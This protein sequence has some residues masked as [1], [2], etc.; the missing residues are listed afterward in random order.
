M[1][2]D[3]VK[4]SIAAGNGGNGIVSF[5][6]EIYVDKGGPDGGDGGKG[7]DVILKASNNQNTLAEFRYKKLLQ[8]ENGQ[9]GSASRKRG[10][11]A[12]NLIVEVP[13]GTSVIT[14]KGTMIVDLTQDGQE[15]IVAQGGRGGFGNAH[16]TSSVRQAPRI[17]EK[18]DQ[19]EKFDYILELK[20]IAD[21]GLVGL[22]NAGKS[23]LLKAISN[24]QP[25][26]ANYPF[27]TLTPNL[28]VVDA[29]KESL[30][31][32]DIPGLIEG[33]SQGKGLGDE[34]LRHV[35]RCSV[36]LHLIDV[37]SSDIVADYKT[38]R[39][40]L[41]AYNK[42][43]G[44]KPEVIAITKTDLYDKDIIDMQVEAL[45]AV[46]PKSAKILSFSAYAKTGL[47]ELVYYLLKVV[48]KEKAKTK[49]K[50]QAEAEKLPVITYIEDPDTWSIDKTEEGFVVT[51]P[52]IETFAMRTDFN[53]HFGE[54]RFRDIMHKMG[55]MNQLQ[56]EGINSGDKIIIGNPPIAEIEY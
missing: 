51:G 33:A 41:Q 50:A 1:F 19:G 32:A 16:F 8:A 44:K 9:N 17:A 7:G 40:E 29:G 28:G 5:R 23:A 39:G 22:P 47:D 36:L 21:V 14:E 46:L 53:N 37:S 45:Q 38:I 54:Q 10:R 48:L 31:V 42:E 35:S 2:V 11:S 49:K 56:K 13:V 24:A 52:K 18:G 43:L 6:H 20:M 55:I 4:V 12:K 25:E 27:T 34:F 3:K 15:A 26:I 30:L